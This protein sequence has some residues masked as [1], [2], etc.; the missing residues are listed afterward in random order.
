MCIIELLLGKPLCEKWRL[1]SQLQAMLDVKKGGLLQHWQHRLCVLSNTRLLIYK[2][3]LTAADA[4]MTTCF[5]TS[6]N[7]TKISWLMFCVNIVHKQ[8]ALPFCI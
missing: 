7:T 1:S 3:K 2:G 8:E 6:P 5:D 4:A